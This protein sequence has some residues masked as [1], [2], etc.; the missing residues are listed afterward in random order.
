MVKCFAYK[1]FPRVK[2]F[3]PFFRYIKFQFLFTLSFE[4]LPGQNNAILQERPLKKKPTDETV[5]SLKMANLDDDWV[6]LGN[7]SLKL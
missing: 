3:P 1:P 6:S 5:G 2:K 7:F 4:I